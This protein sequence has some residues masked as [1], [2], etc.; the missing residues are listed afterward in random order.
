MDTKYFLKSATIQATLRALI[1]TFILIAKAL[2]I[3]L[4]ESEIGGFIDAIST[5]VASLWVMVEFILIVKG[6]WQAK[7]PLRG[8]KY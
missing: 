6:R 4:G 5:I 7:Q 3:Q 8:N 1:P 2:G